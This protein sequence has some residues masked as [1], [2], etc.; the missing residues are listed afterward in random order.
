MIERFKSTLG[1][2]IHRIRYLAAPEILKKDSRD[3]WWLECLIDQ[4]RHWC[5]YDSPEIGF[6]MLELKKRGNDISGFREKLRRGE[7]TFDAFMAEQERLRRLENNS[8]D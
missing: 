4:Q 5:A 1:N 8:H 7:M 2:L 6:A 3:L